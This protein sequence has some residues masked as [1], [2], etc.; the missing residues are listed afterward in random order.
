LSR[1][2]TIHQRETISEFGD[3]DLPLVIGSGSGAHICLPEGQTVEAYIADS[4]G[5][6]FLQP[7]NGASPI[8]H[9][10][11][12]ITSSVWIKSGDHARI[13][14]NTL[15]FHISG[16][17]V[18]I[19]LSTGRE[20]TTSQ[21][22]APP[23]DS[24]AEQEGTEKKPGKTL[25]RV[26][27]EPV[28]SRGGKKVRYLALGIFL[29]LL[30]AAAF[31]LMARSIE[32]T[33][34]PAPEKL[35]V[36]GFPPAFKIGAHYLALKGKYTIQA[37]RPGYRDLEEAVTVA[38]NGSNRF[39]FT[40]E[41]LPGLLDITSVPPEG[42]RVFIDDQLVGRTPL[43]NLEVPAGKHRLRLVKERY[44]S[45]E[46]DIEVEGLGTRQAFN[47]VLQPSWGRVKLAT[48]P[49]GATVFNGE[50]KLG[51]TPLTLEL[52]GGKHLLTLRKKG[53]SPVD[54]NLEVA[55]GGILAPETITL[56]P[57]P[58]IVSLKT[59]PAGAAVTV[60][61]VFAG[62]TPV[63]LS[64]S[65]GKQHEISLKLSG[66][67]SR[68][69][70]LTLEAGASREL[71]FTLTPEYGII[72]LTTEPA[73]ATLMVDGR[74]RGPATGRLRLTVAPHTLTVQ[75]RGYR[76][77][78]QKVTPVKGR[79]QQLNITLKPVGIS[80]RS[81]GSAPKKTASA[82]G[83]PLIRLGPAIFTMGASRREPGRRANEQ[84]RQVKITR[85]FYLAAREVTNA[86]Y[87]RFK[88]GHRSGMVKGKSLDGSAQPVVMVSWED[89]ARYCNW[90]SRQEG[91]SPFYREEHGTM[92]PVT[93]ATNGYRLPF[94][95]E[96]SCAARAAG[97]STPARYPWEGSFP[98]QAASGNY[99]DESG[100]SI[101]S[102]VIKNYNDSYPVT[103]PVASFPANKAG[104]YDLGG[105]VSEWCH[106]FYTPRPGTGRLDV[107]PTGPATGSHHVIRGSSWRD[108]TIS[109]L[110]LSY[111]SY[112]RQPKNDV[113]FRLARYAR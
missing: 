62:T 103:A 40:M 17:R 97:H 23:P 80:S 20:E 12:H 61:G 74:P 105:N 4:R 51:Q 109:E 85:P 106:D 66:H 82:A 94:E 52:P 89:A 44:L 35:A 93:P 30:L 53:F 71:S 8:Y 88:P 47:F 104:F 10:D 29:L 55:P 13:G 24:P 25:P 3:R 99:G 43:S 54:L 63:A 34:S 96:W 28:R 91:L 64:L 102:L 50:A 113:G 98:P 18:E 49:A 69:S 72:F 60:D 108:S 86:E 70:L 19:R 101:L 84:L 73:N 14:S 90:L 75:A 95:A 59:S 38:D 45:I 110:R 57:A 100:R 41:K 7:A 48:D 5:H 77:V 78:R 16:D 46:Q 37:S 42:A 83:Q 27:A 112:G 68:K 87:R 81:A 22:L 9:N 111:R 26:A 67:K 32:I 36:S 33:V 15:R 56:S 79:S 21:P 31:V 65:S 92:V 1:L 39:N 58:A 107:D 2:F 11:A 76:T 6:L